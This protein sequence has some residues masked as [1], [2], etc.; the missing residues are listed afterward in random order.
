MS[1]TRRSFLRTLCVSLFA[2]PTLVKALA[3]RPKLKYEFTFED[4][5]Q[6]ARVETIDYGRAGKYTF[7][8]MPRLIP[9]KYRG[10][11]MWQ[12]LVDKG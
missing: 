12:N 11:L 6:V 10:E 1:T 4:Q 5:A 8:D 2:G 3:K 7:K 9:E